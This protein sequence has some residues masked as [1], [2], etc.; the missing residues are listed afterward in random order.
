MLCDTFEVSVVVI[1][2][3]GGLTYA[4]LVTFAWSLHFLAE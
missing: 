3:V 2:L 4:V 1:A